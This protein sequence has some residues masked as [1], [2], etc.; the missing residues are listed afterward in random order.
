MMAQVN[1]FLARA[2]GKKGWHVESNKRI[3]KGD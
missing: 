2:V 3:K 1:F